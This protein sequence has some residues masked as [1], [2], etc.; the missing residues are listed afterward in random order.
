MSSKTIN[1]DEVEHVGEYDVAPVVRA[2]RETTEAPLTDAKP[3]LDKKELGER[4]VQKKEKS[5]FLGS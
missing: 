3:F 2:A 1:A 5:L 4:L